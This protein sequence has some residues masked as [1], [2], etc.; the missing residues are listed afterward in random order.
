[1]STQ[2]VIHT[3]KSY[4]ET[5]HHGEDTHNF[6]TDLGYGY[7]DIQETLT[8]A[9]SDPKQNW[10]EIDDAREHAVRLVRATGRFEVAK[11]TG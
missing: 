4:G 1:M 7:G 2:T 11:V 9:E 6:L 5:M 10:F 8:I 3:S